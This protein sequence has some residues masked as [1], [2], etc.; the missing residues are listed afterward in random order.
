MIPPSFRFGGS[1]VAGCGDFGKLI[2]DIAGQRDRG[3]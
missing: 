3:G 1:I 2:A